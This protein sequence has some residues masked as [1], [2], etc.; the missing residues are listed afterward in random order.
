VID[1]HLGKYEQ[2]VQTLRRVADLA[3]NNDDPERSAVI[4][5]RIIDSG[6]AEA[7]DY[8]QLAWGD[9]LQDR[10]TATTL[11]IANRGV[12]LTSSAPNPSLLHTLAAVNAEL[13]RTSDARNTLLQRLKLEQSDEPSDDDWYVFGR[14]AELY[15]LKEE[16]AAMYR[17][18]QP[19]DRDM[20]FSATSYALAQ[21]RLEALEGK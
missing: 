3:L 17:R 6:R 10:V 21:R 19:P 7:R 5:R 8:N 20:G 15:G 1:A 18:L 9:I 16:A 13:G 2:D 14:I 11:E 4:T 12:L